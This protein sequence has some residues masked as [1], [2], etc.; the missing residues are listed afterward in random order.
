MKKFLATLILLTSFAAP[1]F[2]TNP[3]NI[4]NIDVS[5]LTSEQKVQLLS[6]VTDLQ[7]QANSTTNISATVRNEASAWGDLGANMGRAAVSA[8]KEIGVAANDFVQTPLGKITMG[9]VIYKVMGG[10][11]VHLVVGV[12]LLILFLSVAIYLLIFKNKYGQVEFE[13]VDGPFNAWK[14]KRLK[15]FRVDSDLVLWNYTAAA[16]MTIGGLIVSLTTI[17][18]V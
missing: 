11:I 2:A 4:S 16:L 8:A 6:Q 15:S 10:A 14:R 5:K 17:F 18:N 7:K 12:S 9:I 13:Y 1:A 3:E